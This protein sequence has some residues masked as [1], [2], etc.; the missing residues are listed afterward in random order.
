MHSLKISFV[1][2]AKWHSVLQRIVAVL[3]AC[4]LRAISPNDIPSE[5]TANSLKL[6]KHLAKNEDY[7]VSK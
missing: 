4:Y 3:V 5:R 1:I 2:I 7:S 6:G